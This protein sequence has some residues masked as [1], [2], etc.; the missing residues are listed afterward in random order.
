[1]KALQTSE[2]TGRRMTILG[3]DIYYEY[4]PQNPSAPTIMLIHGFLSS[5]FSFRRLI[6]Y[7]RQEYNI[8]S[9]DLPPFGSSGKSQKYLYSSRNQALL[10]LE[11]LNCLGIKKVLLAGHSMGG[12]ICLNM[13]Q[14]DS[15]RV[16]GAVLLCS[17]GYMQKLGRLLVMSSRLPFFHLLVKR[18]LEKSGVEENLRS[19]V[20]NQEMIDQDMIDGYMEP[21]LDDQIFKGLT[22][23]IRDREEDLNTEDLKQIQTP[24]LLIW[25]EQDKIVPLRVGQRLESDL[26]HAKLIVFNH[27]GHLLPEE[28][29]E[30]VFTCIKEF[31]DGGIN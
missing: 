11:L 24:C 19:V 22:K 28:E 23:M 17:S 21:F 16:E 25:G 30:K 18:W 29:P 31:I 7:L 5:S 20:F 27:A 4:Y 1:M 6:P 2:N 13:M 12:Q 15:E 3:H 26:P 10:A 14:Q 8:L 9:M